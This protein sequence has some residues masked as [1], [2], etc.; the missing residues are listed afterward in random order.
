MDAYPTETQ[1]FYFRINSFIF[2][3]C[4][5]CIWVMSHLIL[6]ED[7]TLML[8]LWI[9]INFYPYSKDQMQCYIVLIP[10]C[11]LHFLY[12]HATIIFNNSISFYLSL[13]LS[14]CIAL[15]IYVRRYLSLLHSWL[16]RT[17]LIFH[18]PSL[19]HNH[20]WLDRTYL[21][22]HSWLDRTYLIFQRPSLHHFI[23]DWTGHIW[24]S[25]VS[26]SITS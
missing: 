21:I 25:I 12:W 18:R 5:D 26:P 4:K 8:H 2:H 19:H 23:A 22:F 7:K 14:A 10:I 6:N 11:R 24:Y 20:S 1:S 17:Y 3:K 15:M 16:D 9:I 13:L